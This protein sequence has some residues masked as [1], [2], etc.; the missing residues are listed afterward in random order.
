[1]VPK[2]MNSNDQSNYTSNYKI[3]KKNSKGRI[4]YKIETVPE[5][6]H[7][8]SYYDKLSYITPESKYYSAEKK[9]KVVFDQD[10]FRKKE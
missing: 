7:R 2:T 1:M 8:S 9:H 4:E 10:R 3:P 6:S 5:L